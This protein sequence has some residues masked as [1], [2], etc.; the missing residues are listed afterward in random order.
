MR[1]LK[2][3]PLLF[4]LLAFS[5]GAQT[6]TPQVINSAGGHRQAG[7]TG[8]SITDNVGEPF[9]Q[10]IGNANF[11]VT[12]GFL[13]PTFVS[14]GGFSLSIISQTPNCAAVFD[15][16][17]VQAIIENP[18]GLAYTAR[19][20]WSPSNVCNGNNCSK[21]DTLSPGSYS[22]MVLVNYL[23]LGGALKTDTLRSL[24]VTITAANHNC[25]VIV[26][27]GVTPNN[28]GNNDVWHIDNIEEY[29]NNRVT[30]YSRWGLQVF[31]I[32]GYNN[33]DFSWPRHDLLAQLP[34]STYFYIID[35]GDGSGPIKGWVELIKDE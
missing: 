35:L 25:S 32:K 27:S 20:F 30:I 14:N 31:D 11:I 9:T 34:A 15:D 33:K 18:K 26:Y 23:G 28:D 7:N 1:F 8:I 24:P 3:I 4:I 21:I 16:A 29:P 12:Q 19:Y 17:F 10:T 2:I 13:Q 22:V 6:I 5:G